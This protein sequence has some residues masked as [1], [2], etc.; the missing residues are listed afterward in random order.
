MRELLSTARERVE[1][2]VEN[3]QRFARA[4]TNK[5]TMKTIILAAVAIFILMMVASTVILGCQATKEAATKIEAMP[6]ED[7]DVTEARVGLIL[8]VTVYRVMTA[9]N[10]T[11][12][13]LLARQSLLGLSA[14][15]IA[16]LA[17]DPTTVAGPMLLSKALRKAGFRDD[18]AMLVIIITE[19]FLRG[20]FNWGVPGEPLGARARQML[21]T[22]ANALRSGSLEVPSEEEQ[23]EV[24]ALVP[25]ANSL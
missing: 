24:T 5:E 4:K 12:S 19:D 3:A 18:E 17:D 21:R 14:N 23:V 15:I 20:Q 9:G 1:Y 16:G 13:E 25:G 7:F 6:Q 2:D 11:E 8:R 10:P 22:V